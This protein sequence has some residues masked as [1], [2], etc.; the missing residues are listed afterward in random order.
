MWSKMA[1]IPLVV[2]VFYLR[3]VETETWREAAACPKGP[4]FAE[5]TG[6]A[7]P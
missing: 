6:P 2:P 3:E 7:E 4:Q 5:V 1:S